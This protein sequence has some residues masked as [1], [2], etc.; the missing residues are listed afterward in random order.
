MGGT[1]AK[2]PKKPSDS[3]RLKEEA[4]ESV[5]PHG[6]LGDQHEEP[7]HLQLSFSYDPL[8]SAAYQSPQRNPY[9]HTW[10]GR[11]GESGEQS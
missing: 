2:L 3:V 6:V 4:S 11:L 5:L 7:L 9:L 10:K 1:E 8:L